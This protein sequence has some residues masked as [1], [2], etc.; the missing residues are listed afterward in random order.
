MLAPRAR[1][2][3]NLIAKAPP[4][5]GRH[6]AWGAWRAHALRSVLRARP[7]PRPGGDPMAL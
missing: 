3:F 7:E 2:P 1:L 6:N 4:W 5:R